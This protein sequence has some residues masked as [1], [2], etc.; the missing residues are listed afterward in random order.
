MQNRQFLETALVPT[1][2]ISSFVPLVVPQEVP[3]PLPKPTEE[4]IEP[5]LE[6]SKVAV[7]VRQVIKVYL[8]N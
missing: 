3:K 5:E 6:L 8:I 4:E 2:P 7:E 1:Q